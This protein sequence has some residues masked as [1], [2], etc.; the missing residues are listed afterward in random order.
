MSKCSKDNHQIYC[1]EKTNPVTISEVQPGILLADFGRAAYA[2]LEIELESKSGGEEVKLTIAEVYDKF[3][4]RIDQAPSLSCTLMHHTIILSPGRHIYKFYIPPEKDEKPVKSPVDTEIAPFR[5]L[6]IHGY[7]GRVN[8]SDII[9]TA[10]LTPCDGTEAEFESSNN[11]LNQVWELCKYTMKATGC[12]GVFIDGNRERTPYEGDAYINQLCHFCCIGT[13]EIAARTIDYF[14][15]DG[16][17]PFEYALLIPQLAWDYHMYNDDIAKLEEWYPMI[18][19]RVL[20]SLIAPSGLLE[21]PFIKENFSLDELMKITGT[22]RHLAQWFREMVDWPPVERDN[23]DFRDCNFVANAYF[24]NAL[25]KAAFIA[26]LLGKAPDAVRYR[27]HSEKVRT[28]IRETMVNPES[29]LFVDGVGSKH[30]AIM[31]AI[32][33]I[34][35]GIAEEA[36]IS[37]HADF[38]VSKGMGCSVYGAQFLL[39]A[40]YHCGRDTD[41]LRLMATE[42]G[43]RSWSNMIRQGTTITL[44]SWD[45]YFQPSQDWNHAW[46]AAPANIIPR[47]LFGI[48][49][50]EPGFKKFSLNIQPGNL[51]HGYLKHPTKYGSIIVSFKVTDKDLSVELEVPSGTECLVCGE[52]TVQGNKTFSLPV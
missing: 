2:Q 44:E 42:S 41:A 34:V 39:E 31:T 3:L 26:D 25:K 6:E 8:P 33:A 22:T 29:G 49:P 19:D 37:K 13:G 17:W 18:Q 30:T 5:Y 50:F 14:R 43:I 51:T 10:Y 38:L 40:L 9:R 35:F 28:T 27:E 15:K 48:V 16:Q 21:A 4:G 20:L 32:M 7:H 46:G 11:M 45:R 36:E 12:F 52:M 23:Y 24:Y 1:T 47:N